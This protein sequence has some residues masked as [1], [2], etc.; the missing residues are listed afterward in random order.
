MRYALLFM[1][2][3]LS[4]TLFASHW[5]CLA[6][7][8]SKRSFTAY[9]ETIKQAM[10]AADTL[11]KSKS[12]KRCKVAQ[13]FCDQIAYIENRCLV[14]DNEG[15]AWNTTG[16]GACENAIALCRKWQFLRGTA[17]RGNCTIKHP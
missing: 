3:I 9:G 7:D 13:S 10:Q 15:H 5:Q 6:F 16:P 8:E 2:S 14:T 12:R 1:L 17:Q 11:C 4:T